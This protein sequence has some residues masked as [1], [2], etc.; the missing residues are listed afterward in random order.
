MSTTNTGMRL[1]A[2]PEIREDNNAIAFF[3]GEYKIRIR[4]TVTENGVKNAKH[5]T[6]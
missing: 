2:A 6:R 5:F 3:D 1:L 4:S